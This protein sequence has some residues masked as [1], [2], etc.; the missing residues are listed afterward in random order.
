MKKGQTASVECGKKTCRPVNNILEDLRDKHVFGGSGSKM[1]AK[2]YSGA[3]RTV[4]IG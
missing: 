1:G 4:I 2:G 3:R